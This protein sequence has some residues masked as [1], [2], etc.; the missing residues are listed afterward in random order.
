MTSHF[1]DE[2]SPPKRCG[3]DFFFSTI[4]QI[5]AESIFEV[6]VL[7][8]SI[9]AKSL[10]APFSSYLTPLPILG[11]GGGGWERITSEVF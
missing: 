2:K 10:L 4:I 11:K 5:Q 6:D 8:P 7:I 3:G 1:Y 9:R